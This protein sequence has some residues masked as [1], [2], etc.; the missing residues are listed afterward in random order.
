MPWNSGQTF[1]YGSLAGMGV[2]TII[3][4]FGSIGITNK[5]NAILQSQANIARLN[6]QMME[7]NAQQRLRSAEKDQVRLTMQAGQVKGSQKAAIA[8]NGLATN[9]GSAVEVL[10]STDIIKEI[11]SNQI[12]ENAQRDYWGMRMQAAGA[13]SHWQPHSGSFEHCR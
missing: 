5:S 2:A 8:A 6:A 9:E 4:A 3:N 12:K 11:D 7:F 10:S 13:R 1:G